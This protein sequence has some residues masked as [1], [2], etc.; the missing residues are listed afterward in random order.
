MSFFVVRAPVGD[1]LYD[2]VTTYTTYFLVLRTEKRRHTTPLS[3]RWDGVVRLERPG[4][5]NPEVRYR[6]CAKRSSYCKR[7]TLTNISMVTLALQ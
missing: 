7:L 2:A 6:Y 4:K 3:D 5:S 1:L